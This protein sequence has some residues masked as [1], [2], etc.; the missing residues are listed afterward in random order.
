MKMYWED[1]NLK[2]VDTT[3]SQLDFQKHDN[4][5]FGYNY[6]GEKETSAIVYLD[7]VLMQVDHKESTVKVYDDEQAEQFESMASSNTFLKFSP[8]ILLKMEPWKYNADT[9]IN[10]KTFFD[11]LN[12][13]M[14]TLIGD[15]QI[16]LVNHLIINPANSFLTYYSRRLFH[17]GEHSQ[18]ID[19]EFLEY[20]FSIN[21]ERLSYLPPQTYTSK[22]ADQ[23]DSR[24]LLSKGEMAP[25]FKLKDLDG[26]TV[27][28][29]DYRGR[30]VFLDF[31][32]I[33]CG[34]CKIALD[35][36]NR[37]D[38]QFKDEIVPLYINPVD[39]Q[40]K[41]EK[42][43]ANVKVPFPV[44]TNAKQVGE[45][46]GVSGYP[47]FFLIDESGKIEMVFAGYDEEQINKIRL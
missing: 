21:E 18:F 26:N 15:K 10:G 20:D 45:D 11:F 33:R 6:I 41:I 38:F 46:Y 1:P 31:S 8:I 35:E 42:Y 29:S 43:V 44:L 28:L 47:S 37:P 5:Y 40:D 25:D 24:Q 7:D 39:E 23:K 17:N 3:V 13:E 4:K 22:V 34:W 19:I 9:V 16:Y 12:V 36:F 30:K 27:R 14:D 2:E 32:M